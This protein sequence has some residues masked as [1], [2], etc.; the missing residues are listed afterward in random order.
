[1]GAGLRGALRTFSYGC[2]VHAHAAERIAAQRSL[3]PRS[4]C[5]IGSSLERCCPVVWKLRHPV[6][7]SLA[8][9]GVFLAGSL[10]GGL[11][12]GALELVLLTVVPRAAFV[13]ASTRTASE[14][15]TPS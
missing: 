7:G 10:L 15:R 13:L 12:V 1:M 5:P 6:R 3:V 11:G 8:V 14:P 9:L 2:A 4:G